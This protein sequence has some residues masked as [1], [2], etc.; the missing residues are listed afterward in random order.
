[1]H[2]HT[3]FYLQCSK[4]RGTHFNPSNIS[5]NDGFFFSNILEIEDPLF[6]IHFIN[7]INQKRLDIIFKLHKEGKTNKEIVKY[8]RKHKIK[9]RNRRDNYSV[10]DVSMCLNKLFRRE[11]RKNSLRLKLGNWKICN[12]M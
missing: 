3:V 8:L 2:T 9:R 6:S 12:T 5:L 11:Q 10:Q 7:A 4:F 1:M